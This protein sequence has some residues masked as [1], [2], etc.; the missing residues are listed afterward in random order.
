MTAGQAGAGC[1]R[2]C[3]P[4]YLTGDQGDKDDV[5]DQ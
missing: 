1:P 2:A 3:L 4:A 5:S